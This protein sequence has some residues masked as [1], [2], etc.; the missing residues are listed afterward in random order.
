LVRRCCA[1]NYTTRNGVNVERAPM[2]NAWHATAGHLATA[3]TKG[4]STVGVMRRTLTALPTACATLR[5]SRSSYAIG[6]CAR[7]HARE[8]EGRFMTQRPRWSEEHGTAVHEAGHAVVLF[9]EDGRFKKVSI[10]AED[11][12]LGCMHVPP[13]RGRFLPD[14]H[15]ALRGRLR[16]EQEAVSTQAGYWAERRWTRRRPGR[17]DDW[18]AHLEEGAQPV[19]TGPSTWPTLP[20]AAW[21]P[22]QTPG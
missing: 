15:L 6:V 12:S 21:T 1:R 7:E 13:A 2:C 18:L 20:T 11:G 10:R 19:F 17:R 3:R 22:Y 5:V 9:L 8:T 14:G 16:L 4:T